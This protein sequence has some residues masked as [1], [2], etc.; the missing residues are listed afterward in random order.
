MEKKKAL[1]RH[2]VLN[3]LTLINMI[4]GS[5]GISQR[6]KNELQK[7]VKVI[8]LIIS[9][10]DVITGK[11][12]RFLN[13]E[14]DINEILDLTIAINEELLRKRKVNLQLPN[15]DLRV[16]ADKTVV[17][18]FIDQI[19]VHLC[20]FVSSIEFTFDGMGK[21]LVIHFE[22]DKSFELKKKTLLACLKEKS[23]IV[24]ELPIRI[25]MHLMSLNGIKVKFGKKS[26]F[27][28]F[29]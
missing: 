11:E 21:I 15:T 17:K 9:R 10:E 29:P 16:C 4:V 22:G 27:I 19:L 23:C 3:L 28:T 1:I 8:G 5:S 20:H 25:S 26:I 12:I 24:D 18:D 13:E 14:F 2:E 6:D 7:I